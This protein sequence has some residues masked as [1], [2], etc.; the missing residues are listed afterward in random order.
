MTARRYLLGLDVGS[1]FV[2]AALLDADSGMLAGA[3]SSPATEMRI[4]APRPGWAEQD[5]GEWW[6]HVVLATR[7]VLH[8]TSAPPEAVAAIGISYPM[9]GLVL[10]DREQQPLRPAIIWCDSRAVA[11]GDAAFEAIGRVNCFARL[12]NSPGNFTASKLKWV[13]DHEPAVFARADKMLLPGDYV[14]MRL[15]GRAATT[16]CGLSEAVLWDFLDGTVSQDVL[17][18]FGLDPK[19]LP[20]IVPTFGHQGELTAAAAA[21]I[22]LRAGTPV[23]YRAGDQPN[24]AFSLKVLGPGEVAATA[25]TSGVVYGVG[26]QATWDSGS[27]V[28][29]FLH[30]THAPGTP[31]YG[32]LLCVNGTGAVNSWLRR[33]LAPGGAG[34][35]Y[36]EMNALAAGAPIGS[37]GVILLPFGNGA[38][39][40][41]G[42][43][44]PGV[45]VHGLSVVRHDRRH[46]L[47][48]A[49]EGIVFALHHGMAIMRAMGIE[50]HTVRAGRANMFLS[51]VFAH[52]F[53]SVTGTCLELFDTDGA[54]GAARAAGL[55]I[56][57]FGTLAD[58]F[59]SL[60]VLDRIEASAIDR[61]RY[62]EAY[63][64]WEAILRR[65]L[66]TE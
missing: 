49:Q 36:E 20:E 2:K 3:A 40:A 12:L 34:L 4:E 9:H 16:A 29:T 46:L 43:R 26:D 65:E 63:A 33:A 39:R 21:E 48:A 27:R 42:N 56:G 61:E 38:E 22:G 45:S 6:R 51:P 54:Q 23:A 55:G 47:R 44:E 14:A 1:S 5:P 25:G 52:A 10:V 17:G 8:Q 57:V 30:V 64:A 28:N 50:A 19:L 60:R 32:T 24:N 31:R 37:D 41:L 59:A 13:K 15:T 7:Q 66:G 58:A 35:S 62:L 18:V 53:A 11:I